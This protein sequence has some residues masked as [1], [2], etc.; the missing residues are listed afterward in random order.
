MN[1]VAEVAVLLSFYNGFKFIDEQ[2]DSILNQ[3][4]DNFKIDIYIRDDG[5]KCLKSVTKLNELKAKHPKIYIIDGDNIGVVNSFL[6]LLNVVDGY[7]FYAFCDQDDYWLPNKINNA[8]N[9]INNNNP[10]LY[11]GNYTLVDAQLH[12]LKS[13]Y[14]KDSVVPSFH[15][16][17]FKNFCTGC[18]CL[19]NSKL[20]DEVLK[21]EMPSLI[22]MH[23][24]FLLLV[25]YCVGEV[26]YDHDSNILYRQHGFN[27]VGGVTN[28]GDKFKRYIRYIREGNNVRYQLTKYLMVINKNPELKF[29]IEDLL[30]SRT[31]LAK[32]IKLIKN[33][34]WTYKSLLDR[35]S[36][37][38]VVLLYRF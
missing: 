35:L 34:S 17:L 11:C 1:K 6:Y 13:N 21:L 19:I 9:T 18:T 12:P 20:R 33:N 4:S 30:E 27:V 16:A 36:V 28:F 38:M 7:D 26:I 29:F 23:D 32:R 31:D 24:W 3:H 22:P 2:V 14:G 15:N 10:Q 8:V 37:Y 5:S 25:A